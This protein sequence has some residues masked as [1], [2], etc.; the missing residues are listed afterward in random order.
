MKNV[1]HDLQLRHTNSRIKTKV[2]I[3]YIIKRCVLEKENIKKRINIALGK[4]KAD[5]VIKN[6][7][8]MHVT[9]FLYL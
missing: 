5:L 6:A 9:A 2:R 1:E 4:E 7:W 8:K 3:K